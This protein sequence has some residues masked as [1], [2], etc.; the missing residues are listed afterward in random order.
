MPILPNEKK[1]LDELKN[2]LIRDH[3][4]LDFR[5]YGSKARGTD[6]EDS[7]L[8]V[9]VLLEN[10]SPSIESE[11]DNLIFEINLKY[12]CFITALYF[13]R[14]ELETGP[15]T[16]SPIY[17]KILQEGITFLAV[18]KSRILADCLYLSP[19]SFRIQNSIFFIFFFSI[20][21]EGRS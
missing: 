14:E 20:E 15:L 8:D 7:D 5:I 17:R 9:M 6:L 12:D 2:K 18:T 21:A 1:A 16:E 11:I 10:T 3:D 19:S 4:L 13:C